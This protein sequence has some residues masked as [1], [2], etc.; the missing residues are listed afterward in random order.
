M[1]TEQKKSTVDSIVGEM[2]KSF[3]VYDAN[4]PPRMIELYEAPTDAVAGSPCVKTT[5]A[6]V[7]T[8]S[9]VEKSKEEPAQ[10]DASYDI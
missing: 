5:F 10:W 9:R 1:A 3:I 6:Y 8:T 4:N 7:G 2:S